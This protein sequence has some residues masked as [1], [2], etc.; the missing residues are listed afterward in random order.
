VFFNFCYFAENPESPIFIHR[1]PIAKDPKPI[2]EVFNYLKKTA[3]EKGQK[4]SVYLFGG[5]ETGAVHGVFIGTELQ[6]KLK[7]KGVNVEQ[8]SKAVEDVVGGKSGGKDNQRTGLG[9]RPNT[10]D[11]GVAAAEQ[12]LADLKI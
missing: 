10:I 4:K 1:L 9:D 12:F 3:G 8:W 6:P 7:E 2:V 11:A 5:N